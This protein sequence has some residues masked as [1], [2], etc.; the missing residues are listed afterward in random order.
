[1]PDSS[2][3]TKCGS[4]N[5]AGASYCSACGAS[6]AA[7]VHC[8]SCNSLNPLGNRFCTRCGGGLEHA[9]WAGPG[10]A[11]AIVDGVWERGGDELIRR[12]DP[13]DARRFLGTRTVRV[14]AG[15]VGVVLVDG[16]VERVLPPGERTTLGLFE[17]IANFFLGRDRT[18]FYLVDQ[19][20]FPVPFVVQTRPGP[21]GQTVKSQV[22]AT[23]TLPRGDHAALATFIAAVLGPRPAFSTGDLYNLVRPDVVRIAQDVLEREAAVAP[24]GQLSY[25]DAEA[26]IRTALAAAVGR[27]YGL[28]VDAT[29]AP[30]TRIA[31]R[32]LRLGTGAAPQVRPC[33]ACRRELPVSLRFCD[34][35]GAKQPTFVVGGEAPT[36]ATPLFTA[37]GQQVE[38]ELVIRL[39]GQ[40]D[41]FAP[42]TIAP[43]LVGAAAAHLRDRPF[44]ALAGA[45]GFT[46]LE[47]A[48][49]PATQD[50]LA[51]HGLTL[52]ALAVV[53]A[54]TKTGDWLLSARAD[55]ERARED[56]RL[57]L[58]WLEQRD[59][60]LDLEELTITRVLRDQRL[61]R[62]QAFA[63]D[64]AAVADRER[65]DGL[66]ARQAAV[67]VA[68][69]QRDGATRAVIDGVE[70]D[71]QRRD[72]A[73]A[74]EQRRTRVQA[75]LDELKA[76]RDLDFADVER[77]KRL[78]LELAA[79][80][81]A[82]QLD[83]LRAMAEIDRATAA[84]DHAHDLEKRRALDGLTPEQMIAVQAAELAR[85]D[86][87]GAAWAN[88]LAQRNSGDAERRHA[89]ETR[90]VYDRA[91]AAMAEVA[92]SRATAAPVV[93]GGAPVVT[94]AGTTTTG[95]P[96]RACTACGAALKPDAAFCGACG[97][98][99]A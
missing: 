31:S 73:F 58:E 76:R 17:R 20:P 50:A 30:L 24:G 44:A 68:A 67:D 95:G 14:P 62:D 72:L 79:V 46:A 85:T 84:Q 34:A 93:A 2:T 16:V 10:E 98:S 55:L 3:C 89:E 97:A 53:D 52:V 33:A 7:Q 35:C 77:R 23:F 83:K 36:A 61:R 59:T 45:G 47:Q 12:V 82:Q 21:S 86:G 81:E 71:R 29:L 25:P 1:M 65:R 91:M 43:A 32:T 42:D 75:E 22:L 39:Q 11:G 40:H 99:Q 51:A 94:V 74:T 64:E 15:T 60:E 56:V 70:H 9:G 78:E 19:R 13:E 26:A 54:R 88:V 57:G 48:M 87:G 4:A 90:A 27:R 41:D 63:R 8:P 6:L 66:A 49:T 38:L 28:T 37:D 18:A 96:G 69:A 92:S 80:A 5:D